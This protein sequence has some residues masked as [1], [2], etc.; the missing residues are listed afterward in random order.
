M[1]SEVDRIST[2]VG[3]IAPSATLAI[4]AKAR[5]LRAQGVKVVSFGAG[6][7][8]FATLK[9]AAGSVKIAYPKPDGLLTFDRAS[10]LF[11][12]GTNERLEK[13]CRLLYDQ[14]LV[15]EGSRVKDPLQ[16]ARALNELLA[17]DAAS[18]PEP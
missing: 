8:D 1:P 12:S 11:L 15:A 3:A 18:G 6:E 16:F 4:D 13:Y 2:L 10:S 14:A 17:R 5:A 7:P 9:P